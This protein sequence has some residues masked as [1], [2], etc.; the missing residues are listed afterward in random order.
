GDQ[1]TLTFTATNWNT[2]QN[3]TVST[4]EDD[5]SQ[6]ESVAISLTARGGGYFDVG[7]SLSLSI[8]DSDILVLSTR[9]LTVEEDD[10]ATFTVKLGS[11]PTANVEVMLA[12][13][14]ASSTDV[15]LDKTSL[16]FT[17]G[18][19]NVAQT[20]TVSAA[21]DADAE[22]DTAM[23]KLTAAGGGYDN[24][25]GRVSVTV[26]E[27]ETAS[28]DISESSL[29]IDEGGSDTFTVVLTS[30]PSDDVTVTLAQPD[31]STNDDVMLDK[32]SLT[33]TT[34]NWNTAQ[35]VTVSADGDADDGTA[36]I[37]LA[38][39][40][41]GYAGVTGRVT[42][43]VR[44]IDG[45]AANFNPSTLADIIAT[46]DS[47]VARSI[48][49]SRRP[50][51]SVTVALSSTNPDIT[52]ASDAAGSTAITS[53]SFTRANW[54][55]AQTFHTVLGDDTDTDNDTATVTL[56]ASGGD[57]AGVTAGYGVRVIDTGKPNIVPS[58]SPV[59][60]D[61]DGGAVTV[62]VRLSEAV[63]FS[64]TATK[65]NFEVSSSDPS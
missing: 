19:W 11:E 53:L 55:T 22:V 24:V 46:E 57:F 36:T 63:A 8:T 18:N 30:E 44:D 10:E 12:R 3:L 49:L 51:A 62:D 28:L 14:D 32:T 15:T 54:S 61:E 41:G 39:A 38:A 16:T 64:G 21:D 5:D 20:V 4:S 26:T 6:D 59:A 56:T 23:I 25:E 48:A 45:G 29:N 31:D 58:I 60:L 37:N 34:G 65:V 52:F 50:G 7:A 43:T 40:G 17:T 2:A 13:T 9:T 27:N 1:N 33:F 42:I 47:V 35:T